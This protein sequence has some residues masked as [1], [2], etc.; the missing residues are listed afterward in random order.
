[1]S[2]S[3]LGLAQ[4]I[5]NAL[6]DEGYDTPTPIQAQTIPTAI[7]GHDLLGCAQTGTGKTAAF[8][9][10][11]LHRLL[12]ERPAVRGATSA[13]TGTLP[14]ALILSPTRELATQI[15]QSFQTYGRH[16]G[17]R[18]TCV[19]GGVS[20]FHQERALRKGVDVLVAT[21]GRLIDLLQQRVVNLSRVSIFVLDEADRMLDMGFIHPIR[22]IAGVLP[23]P[24]QTML[25]SATMPK[26]IMSLADSLLKSPVKV[27]VSPATLTV[28]AIAQ[29]IH[30]VDRQGKL[31]LLTK[32][33]SDQ[34][35]ERAVVFTRTK[36]GADKLCRKLNAAGVLSDSIHGNK[37]Q[38]QRQRA[39]DGFRTGKSR[40]L[41]ATDVAARGLDVD[42]VTHVFNY[43]LP[44]DPEAYVHRIGRTGRAGAAGVAISFCDG[45]ERGFLRD[46]E[47]L[48]GRRIP[49]AGSPEAAQAVTVAADT[50]A[51]NGANAAAKASPMALEAKPAHKPRVLT[52]V[53]GI[54]RRPEEAH[55]KPEAKAQAH[56]HGHSNGHAGHAPA[57][58]A[59]PEG[60]ARVDKF[61]I[62]PKPERPSRK[63]MA[64]NVGGEHEAPAAAGA[65]HRNGR[66][67]SHGHGHGHKKGAPHASRPSQGHTGE[68]RVEGRGGERPAPAMAAAGAGSSA[69]GHSGGHAG[70]HRGG[71]FHGGGGKYG[72]RFGQKRGAGGGWN[73]KSSGPR[74]G[75]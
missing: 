44:V 53:T 63:A 74:R 2:F 73:R 66:A 9:L 1:M 52:P 75:R 33:L 60:F 56:P 69:G 3:T 65:D 21:P 37:A 7:E 25:F 22:Q 45:E 12:T 48:I 5:L 64:A 34:K 43:D 50:V 39:L 54:G 35:A 10:P 16:T 62:G 72:N 14:R 24:R 46:I 71:P 11:I 49:L 29:S 20:Q 30:M 61:S 41:V 27:S 15:G 32:L 47:R 26:E 59:K 4:P 17:L 6:C 13:T 28:P 23:T 67:H 57:K 36:H 55:R 40:V 68:R 18:V 19:F 38:N 58:A 70:G 51:A 31:P 42:G 8:A